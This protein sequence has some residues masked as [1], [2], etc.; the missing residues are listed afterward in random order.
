MVKVSDIEHTLEE[1]VDIYQV[2]R[3]VN[4]KGIYRSNNKMSLFHVTLLRLPREN[5]TEFIP[6]SSEGL[7][8]RML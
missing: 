1:T 6:F 8:K 5:A 3:L 7:G 2:R 4:P